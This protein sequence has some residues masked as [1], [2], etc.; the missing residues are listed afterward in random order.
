LNNRI[1]ELELKMKEI[2]A[3]DIK[4]RLAQIQTDIE[5]IKAKLEDK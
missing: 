2:D 5:R 3:I 4:T 1:K